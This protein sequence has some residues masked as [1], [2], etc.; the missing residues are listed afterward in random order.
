M[1]RITKEGYCSCFKLIY[2]G[3]YYNRQTFEKL[4]KGVFK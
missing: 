3:Y 4:D 1:F 2:V